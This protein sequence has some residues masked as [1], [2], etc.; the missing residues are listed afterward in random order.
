MIDSIETK[1]RR[2]KNDVLDQIALCFCVRVD[3]R[4]TENLI[5]LINGR[6]LKN[7]KK[8]ATERGFTG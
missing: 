6:L 7:N 2:K 8:R 4:G 3:D 1:R 5:H